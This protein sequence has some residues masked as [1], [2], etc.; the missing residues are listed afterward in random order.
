LE[1]IDFSDKG[2]LGYG[3]SYEINNE[4]LYFLGTPDK[5]FKGK[6]IVVQITNKKEKI[7]KEIF[8]HG[9]SSANSLN[10]STMSFIKSQS[11]SN[12]EIL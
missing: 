10:T 1:K 3:I 6:T 12:Y 11:P 8:I 5:R 4:T 2:K 7:L 9:I